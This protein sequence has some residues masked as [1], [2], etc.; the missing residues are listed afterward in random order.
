LKRCVYKNITLDIDRQ[1][2]PNIVVD[3]LQIV[4]KRVEEKLIGE[5]TQAT[6]ESLVRD[7]ELE[8]IKED[9]IKGNELDLENL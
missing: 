1:H 8:E 4:E 3:R 9:F 7:E 6:M 2:D 5:K